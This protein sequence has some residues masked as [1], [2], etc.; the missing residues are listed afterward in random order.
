VL[1]DV[2]AVA[3]AAMIVVVL[4]TILGAAELLRERFGRRIDRVTA[5]RRSSESSWALFDDDRC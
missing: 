3:A 2:A 1:S 5:A 4:A